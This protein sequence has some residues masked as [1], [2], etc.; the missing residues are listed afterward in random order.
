MGNQIFVL[1]YLKFDSKKEILRDK[2]NTLL[3]ALILR[4]SKNL[5]LFRNI[6][7]FVTWFIWALRQ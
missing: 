7:R 1:I 3:E 6:T 2:K 4:F 5:T